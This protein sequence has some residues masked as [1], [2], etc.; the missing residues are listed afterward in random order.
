MTQR[1]R[2]VGSA[3]VHAAFL[4]L[5]VLSAKASEPVRTVIL[6]DDR[7]GT[8]VAPLLLL[9]RIDV[10]ENLRLSEGQTDNA[11]RVAN[12]MFLEA[13]A[14]SGKRGAEFI[15]ARK[16]IDESSTRWIEANL[17]SDQ[18]TRLAQ[19][20]LQWEGLSALVSR[21]LVVEALRLTEAQ[22]NAIR[23]GIDAFHAI[24]ARKTPSAEEKK[25]SIDKVLG[26]LDPIQSQRW[27]AILGRPFVPSFTRTSTPSGPAGR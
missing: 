22:R 9:T 8:R 13:G 17:T 20:D 19:I 26:V 16:S 6:P 10:R 27:E 1:V 14:L 2:R 25:T 12:Q 15:A 23:A 24:S 3:W 18:Q 4:A 5:M 7:Y 21:P 11:L